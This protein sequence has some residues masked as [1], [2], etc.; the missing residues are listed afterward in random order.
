MVREKT[1]KIEKIA[2]RDG[3]QHTGRTGEWGKVVVKGAVVRESNSLLYRREDRRKGV[4]TPPVPL[5]LPLPQSRKE[6]GKG[7]GKRKDKQVE[8]NSREGTGK[9]PWMR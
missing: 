5:H 4:K 6:R 1:K 8:G 9:A 7:E 2:G 3:R